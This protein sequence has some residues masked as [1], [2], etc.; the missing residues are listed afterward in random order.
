ME[1]KW[2]FKPTP[3]QAEE[4]QIVKNLEKELSINTS[5]AN[6]LWQRGVSTFDEAKHFFRPKIEDLHDPFLMA[7]MDLAVDRLIKAVGGNEKILIFG[8]YDV[9]GTTAV[10]LFYGFL[11]KYYKNLEYYNPDRY[12]EGYGI[13]TQG[14]DYASEIGATLIISLDCGI[15]SI[16]KIDYATAQ[17]GIDFI[18]C[19][20]HEPGDELPAAVAILDPKR[21]DCPYPFKELT[22]NGVG[23]KL[24]SAFCKLRN[25]PIE[26]LFEFLDL[27]MVSIASDIVPIV[28]EN[29]ILAYYGLKKINENP[30]IGLKALKQVA[31]FSGEM[32]IE[33]VVFV[34]GPRINAAGRIKH[35]KAAVQ[36]LLAEDFD[37]ALSFA[38]EIQNNN[39]ERKGHDSRITE[40]AL[41]M[42]KKDDWLLNI[43]KSTVLYSENWHKGV[44]GIVASRCIE[45]FH[46]P[47]I[48]FTKSRENTAAGSAR[49]VPGFD[50]YQA[51]ERCAHL[52]IQFGGHMHAAG[53]TIEIDKI[54]EFRAQFDQ[55]VNEMI[56]EEQL[57]PKINIDIKLD[58][59]EISPKFYRIM[60]QMAPFGPQNMQ[61][62]F[63]SENL[64]LA[65]EPRI[66]KEKHLKLEI[67]DE[68]TGSIY[69]AIGFGMVEDHYK[70]LKDGQRFKMAYSIEE[71]TFRDRTSLQ[72]FIRD[73]KF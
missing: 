54:D 21:L 73:I 14:I 3:L 32:S 69:S 60:K 36:L 63:V 22:G 52:L 15:K 66:L 40:E 70:K 19:D 61:P 25:I 68:E 38:Y 18:I 9:D 35:A 6:M 29:R 50:L 5:L 45:N 30:R 12:K 2:N 11:I 37:D 51:I 34:L 28:G 49:S 59:S 26:E 72:L 33:N 16:D 23:F 65:S 48:I 47:T 13:S 8:D 7:D 58:L 43:A 62:I 41:E 55:I 10:S 31:G 27:A 4:L 20:H 67:L 1:K 53:M 44:I 17:Y 42:I 57:V 46:R 24:L 39:T 71:N 64:L 56:L